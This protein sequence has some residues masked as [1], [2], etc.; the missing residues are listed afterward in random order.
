M[1]M[2]NNQ[3]FLAYVDFLRE[4]LDNLSDYWSK[5]GF[6]HP[7]IRQITEALHDDDPF[8]LYGATIAASIL[9][10]DQSIYH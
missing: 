9:L 3:S 1:S 6:Y 5:S 4:S 10:E 8:I 7:Q 2:I